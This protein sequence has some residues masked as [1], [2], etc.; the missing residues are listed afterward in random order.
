MHCTAWRTFALTLTFIC[1][2][3]FLND[4]PPSH[5]FWQNTNDPLEEVPLSLHF[6]TWRSAHVDESV[7]ASLLQ[8]ELDAGF[9]YRYEGT[10][11]S[12]RAEWP[13]G[14]ALGKLRVGRAPG[15]KERLVL[16]NSICGTNANCFVPERQ[17]TPSVRD[18]MRSFPLRGRRNL[19]LLSHWML[20]VPISG[21]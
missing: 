14:L 10:L 7:T 18:V 13:T 11:E 1:S 5:C 15:R 9:C 12:A 21:S 6:Q 16:D 2:H 19:R 20:K 8:E 3:R 4:I 17:L